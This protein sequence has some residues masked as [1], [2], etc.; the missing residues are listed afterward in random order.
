[1]VGGRLL[2]ILTIS[3]AKEVFYTLPEKEQQKLLKTAVKNIVAVKKKLGDRVQFYQ[4][5]GWGRTMSIG[6]HPNVEEY[7]QCLQGD[8]PGATFTDV[9]TYLLSELDEKALKAWQAWAESP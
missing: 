4:E 6:E 2:K 8:T 9:E 3:K 1:M 5:A 7:M